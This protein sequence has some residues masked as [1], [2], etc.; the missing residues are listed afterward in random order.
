[1]SDTSRPRADA[2]RHPPPARPSSV[3]PYLGRSPSAPLQSC[4][5]SRGR[6]GSLDHGRG[7][8]PRRTQSGLVHRQFGPPVSL[9]LSQGPTSPLR[10]PNGS[11]AVLGTRRPDNSPA[12]RAACPS[13]PAPAPLRRLRLSSIIL[14]GVAP[15]S[16][17]AAGAACDRFPS[18]FWASCLRSSAKP[19]APPFSS[20]RRRLRLSPKSVR[21]SRDPSVSSPVSHSPRANRSP[22]QRIERPARV[23][24]G[25]SP[26]SALRFGCCVI[27]ALGCAIAAG[28]GRRC[29]PAR[30]SW[31]QSASRLA[32]SHGFAHGASS[33]SFSVRP[34][35]LHRLAHSSASVEC[36]LG[37]QQPSAR[38]CCLAGAFGLGA[39][40]ILPGQTQ[41]AH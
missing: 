4:R 19:T 8:S 9:P 32:Q 34:S 15:S 5:H 41:T 1:M 20:T 36:R 35:A 38:P 29:P 23:I 7:L 3:R 28:A 25:R 16:P 17:G 27:A 33:S 12:P 22:K 21:A 10:R 31:P 18:A 2:C 30:A 39:A 40:P 13:R 24:S 6:A 11:P 37:R 14:T 26:S